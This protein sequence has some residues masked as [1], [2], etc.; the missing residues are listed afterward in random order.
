VAPAS[1]DRGSDWPRKSRNKIRLVRSPEQ[2]KEF[3]E[4]GRFG[5]EKQTLKRTN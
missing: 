3:L 5:E 1:G 2:Q 4:H